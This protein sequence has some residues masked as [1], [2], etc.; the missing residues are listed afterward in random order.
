MN[1]LAKLKE[2]MRA[3]CNNHL[4]A[5]HPKEACQKN[6]NQVAG[7][8]FISSLVPEG[9]LQIVPQQHQTNELNK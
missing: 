3:N 9:A 7:I 6:H 2:I 8:F 4:T 1:H 5:V